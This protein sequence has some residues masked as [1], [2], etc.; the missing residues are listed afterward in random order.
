MATLFIFPKKPKN[1]FKSP[2]SPYSFF[3]YK[4]HIA[5]NIAIDTTMI[6]IMIVKLT[7]KRILFIK[8]SFAFTP[9]TSKHSCIH[10]STIP[11]FLIK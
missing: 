3:G 6:M 11:C 10:L 8:G 7:A 9:L 2:L 1:V 4:T 5:M